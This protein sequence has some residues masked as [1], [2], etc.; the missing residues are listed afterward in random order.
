[1]LLREREERWVPFLGAAH[2]SLDH[3][4][5][6]LLADV[7]VLSCEAG[8][9]EVLSLEDQSEVVQSGHRD[10][11]LLRD[12]LFDGEDALRSEVVDIDRDSLA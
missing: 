5:R 11:F 8:L 1:M 2:D 7:V 6:R 10:G 12:L 3:V 4:D 9:Q